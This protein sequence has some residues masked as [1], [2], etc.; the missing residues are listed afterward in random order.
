MRIKLED[1]HK[2]YTSVSKSG[3]SSVQAVAGISLDIPENTIFGIIDKG[4]AGKSSL[5]RLVSLLER[6]DSGA[7]YYDEK[8]V[9]NL[10]KKELIQQRRKTGMIFQNFNLFSSRDESR[11][12]AS[13]YL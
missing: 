12:Q 5:V 13:I 2:T 4:G 8:R 6:P 3:K 10:S 11:V 1:L 9:D 7:V